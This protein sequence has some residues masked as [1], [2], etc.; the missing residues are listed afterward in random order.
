MPDGSGRLE[1]VLQAAATRH[2]ALVGHLLEHAVQHRALLPVVLIAN[3]RVR[4]VLPAS[5]ARYV[6]RVEY[7]VR[8]AAHVVDDGAGGRSAGRGAHVEQRGG[9]TRPERRG[10]GVLPE[11]SG[12]GRVARHDEAELDVGAVGEDDE[13]GGAAAELL[14]HAVGVVARVGAELRALDAAGLEERLGAV[15]GEVHADLQR[16]AHQRLHRASAAEEHVP[17][18]ECAACLATR[19]RVERGA[20]RTVTERGA[21]EQSEERKC[22]EEQVLHTHTRAPAAA[23]L[24]DV[25]HCVRCALVV[26]RA[27]N[28]GEAVRVRV[29][30]S[31]VVEWNGAAQTGAAVTR[32]RVEDRA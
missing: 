30:W 10:Q 28:S 13:R 9:L 32:A 4:S 7:V 1:R 25:L 6:P 2:G 27:R 16:H 8:S 20:V 19:V 3:R 18:T 29:E 22:S 11:M 15:L 14:L 24:N 5:R 17:A 31:R 12:A 21:C 26:W 23:Q